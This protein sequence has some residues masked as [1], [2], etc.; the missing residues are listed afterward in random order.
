MLLISK[1]RQKKK[2]IPMDKK[3]FQ[4]FILE[5]IVTLAIFSDLRYLHIAKTVINA[6]LILITIALSQTV[7]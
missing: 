2:K 6:Y 4:E 3:K 5:D 1:K 7:A